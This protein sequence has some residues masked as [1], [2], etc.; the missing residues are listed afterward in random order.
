VPNLP[1]A[2]HEGVVCASVPDNL[3]IS[4][5]DCASK[6]DVYNRRYQLA[7][8]PFQQLSNLSFLGFQEL[9]LPLHQLHIWSEHP[10]FHGPFPCRTLP[11][12]KR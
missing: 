10:P 6:T 11:I 3:H 1:G 7:S 4:T 2:F 12:P 8:R 9:V 5:N